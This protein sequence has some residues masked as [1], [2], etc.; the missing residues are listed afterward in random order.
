MFGVLNRV[1]VSLS[2]PNPPTQIPVEYTPRGITMYIKLISNL[3]PATES[4]ATVRSF[5]YWFVIIVIS[6]STQHLAAAA[7]SPKRKGAIEM[8]LKKGADTSLQNKEYV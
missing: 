3:Y 8:L 2:R 7:T 1:W 5:L 6:L 4:Q